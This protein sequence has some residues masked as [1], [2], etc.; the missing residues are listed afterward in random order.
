M[1]KL[2]PLPEESPM[3]DDDW[4]VALQAQFEGT[5]PSTHRDDL[6]NKWMKAFMPGYTL[7]ENEAD[8]K[9]A[10]L[11]PDEFE[12]NM[13]EEMQTS[14]ALM[15]V[16]ILYF[17]SKFYGIVFEDQNETP[18]S[19]LYYA[20]LYF[21]VQIN[22]ATAHFIR[23]TVDV[24]TP[25]GGDVTATI[26]NFFAGLTK[27]TDPKPSSILDPT[28]LDT[29]VSYQSVAL[30]LQ[31]KSLGEFVEGVALDDSVTIL[32]D[33]IFDLWTN[34]K[35]SNT[36]ED[37]DKFMRRIYYDIQDAETRTDIL[38]YIELE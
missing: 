36:E 6:L 32:S 38:R 13:T 20:Y 35:I 3:R 21:V 22:R 14:F 15:R 9:V 4:F 7:D 26:K 2:F 10:F 19:D 29:S 17:F 18:F 30:V 5:I 34:G 12:M 27:T 25:V 28:N 37:Q 16:K 24:E 23:Y 31:A 8:D 1:D 11:D 33:F